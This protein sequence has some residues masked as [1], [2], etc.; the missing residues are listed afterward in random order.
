[1]RASEAC[2][3]AG[4]TYRQFDHWATKGYLPLVEDTDVSLG[5]GNRREISNE[6]AEHLVLMAELV[7]AGMNPR[8]ASDH[9]RK[10]QTSPESRWRLGMNLVLQ[11][12]SAE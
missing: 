1:M 10:I 6:A 5:S 7:R 4:I 8:R 12:E 11:K 9:A 3:I 2:V